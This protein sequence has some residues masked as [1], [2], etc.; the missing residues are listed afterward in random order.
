MSPKVTA[1]PEHFGDSL[2]NRARNL[3]QGLGR[4]PS[5]QFDRVPGRGGLAR[6]TPLGDGADEPMGARLAERSSDDQADQ[7]E[8]NHVVDWL[9]IILGGAI[10]LCFL[11]FAW[12]MASEF[13][14]AT[15]TSF[16]CHQC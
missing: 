2:S 13:V 1:M 10:V 9:F 6:A 11:V 16:L 8:S 15:Q 7:P 12:L 5:R 14:E 4:G 3:G